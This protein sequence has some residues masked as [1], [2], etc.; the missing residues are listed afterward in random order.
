MRNPSPRLVSV[1]LLSSLV[2]V[3]AG[4]VGCRAD[5]AT[6]AQDQA[7][8]SQ[9]TSVTLMLRG[10]KLELVGSAAQDLVTLPPGDSADGDHPMLRYAFVGPGGSAQGKVA[11]P[12]V[13]RFELPDI[14]RSGERRIPNGTLTLRLPGP[15]GSL[16]LTS[17]DGASLHVDLGGDRGGSVR[18]R[19]IPSTPL[20]EAEVGAA[21]VPPVVLQEVNPCSGRVGILFMPEGYTEAELPQFHDDVGN[22]LAALRTLPDMAALNGHFAFAYQDIASAESGI[23]RGDVPK[24]TAFGMVYEDG[25]APRNAL[26]LESTTGRKSGT[27]ELMRVAKSETGS[28]IV[29]IVPNV[30]AGRSSAVPQQITLVNHGNAPRTMLHE[31]GHAVAGLA[32]EYVDERRCDPARAG[33]RHNTTTDRENPPWAG[34]YSGEPVL[35]AEYCAAGVYRPTA[36]C[37]MRNHYDTDHLCP[38]CAHQFAQTFLGRAQAYQGTHGECRAGTAPGG[39]KAPSPSGM[40]KTPSSSG[41]SGEPPATTPCNL[42]GQGACGAGNVCAWTGSTYC[43]KTARAPVGSPCAR[44]SE[45]GA[46]SVCAQTQEG[47][48]LAC[49]PTGADACIPS[50]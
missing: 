47:G 20:A 42:W 44:D 2:P 13:L 1:L 19:A 5:E 45:C 30:Q 11:D 37:L 22:M 40:P 49:V 50:R 9:P 31:L 41:G 21:R 10:D 29:V 15:R 35:G 28:E 4:A 6:D 25:E 32:D 39:G 38:V 43:C 17:E 36:E 26:V 18:P 23:G 12:R 46:G 3:L 48:R 16:T 7:E 34:I 24:D 8:L 14:Q 33:H 27:N